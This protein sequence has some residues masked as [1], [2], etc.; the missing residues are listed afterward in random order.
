[1]LVEYAR[2]VLGLADAGHTEIRPDASEPVVSLLACSLV[3]ETHPVNVVAGTHAAGLYDKT[4]VEEAFFCSYGLNPAYRQ[5]LEDAG[6]RVSAV[7]DEGDVRVAELP[8][9]PF[10]MGTL[11]VPQSN[12]ER[13]APHPLLAG[14]AAAAEARA[15][16]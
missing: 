8:G 15:S 3:G 1:V 4:R 5:A 2:N 9:H 11:F 12:P 10:F 16:S 14:F 13:G 6:L 7:D